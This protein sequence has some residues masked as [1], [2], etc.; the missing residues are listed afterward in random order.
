VY[1]TSREVGN[2]AAEPAQELRGDVVLGFH[3][4][5]WVRAGGEPRSAIS[6][7]IFF[8]RQTP[9]ARQPFVLRAPVL[10]PY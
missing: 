1:P 10:R 8:K 6:H 7:R 2:G 3:L 5:I 9:A 4:H